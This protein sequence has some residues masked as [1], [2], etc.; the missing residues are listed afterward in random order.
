MNL[1]LH[2][3][4]LPA[5]IWRMVFSN[6]DTTYQGIVQLW[7]NYRSVS[8]LFKEEAE[9]FLA[10][11]FVPKSSLYISNGRWSIHIDRRRSLLDTDQT[12]PQ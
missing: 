2:G 7:L 12:S 11:K 8:K 5:E 10:H 9:H 3:P 1:S 6:F 4:Q